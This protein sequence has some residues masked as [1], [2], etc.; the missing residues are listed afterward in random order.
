MVRNV[1]HQST[2]KLI[3]QD[4][5]GLGGGYAAAPGISL[6]GGKLNSLR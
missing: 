4:V 2:N 1:Q 6:R 5:V 3:C